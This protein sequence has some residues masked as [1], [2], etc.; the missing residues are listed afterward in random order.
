MLP[1]HLSDGHIHT[2][3]CNH[4]TGTMEE[5]V[6]AALD[7]KLHHICFLEHMEEGIDSPRITWLSEADFDTYF[8]E[9]KRL[10]EK[11]KGR[12]SIGLGVEVGYNPECS[13]QLVKRLSR[14]RWD[15]IG[16]SCH[17]HR[18]VPGSPHLNLVSKKAP[19]LFQLSREEARQVEAWYYRSLLEAV[20]QLPGTVLCHIDAALR[21]HPDRGAIEPPYHLIDALLDA[22]KKKNMALEVNTSGMA[23]RGEVFPGRKIAAMALKKNIPLVAGSDAHSPEHV[24]NHFDKLAELLP[25]TASW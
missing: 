20:T 11:Y 10:Q 22:V 14:R 9:G 5:Y 1:D 13:E 25:N 18:L 24:G 3:L 8:T 4:A 23:V 15:R 17:F 21:Y 2:T 6:S 16:V 19:Q 7:A 12:I